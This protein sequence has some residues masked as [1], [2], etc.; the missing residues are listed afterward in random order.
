MPTPRPESPLPADHFQEGGEGFIVRT[1][2][3]ADD[4]PAAPAVSV[5]QADGTDRTTS[6]S[7]GMLRFN[8]GKHRM[9]LIPASFGR[10]TA[11]VLEYGAIK[12]DANNWRRGG[13]WTQILDSLQRHIDAFR[14]GEDF[15]KE[16]GLPHVAHINFGAMVL[17][18]FFDKNIG[19]DTRFRYADQPSDQERP[20]REL[21][22]NQPPARSQS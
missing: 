14:E 4:A 11:A 16:S 15:D 13:D 21:K 5:L 10:Y 20:G 7:G 9:T 18:E 2:P 12:Y 22:F 8:S 6:H 1:L 19:T 3:Q 17:T